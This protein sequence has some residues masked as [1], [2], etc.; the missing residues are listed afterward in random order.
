MVQTPTD[1][2]PYIQLETDD[3]AN[4][5]RISLDSTISFSTDDTNR[6][7]SVWFWSD[8]DSTGQYSSSHALFGGKYTNYWAVK[9]SGGATTYVKKLKQMVEM[10]EIMIIFQTEKV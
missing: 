6:T 10:T 2:H 3:G 4:L 1:K 5:R 7:M 9:N 8:Y